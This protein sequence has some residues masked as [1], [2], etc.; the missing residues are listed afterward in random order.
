M[1]PG[2]KFDMWLLYC[3][4][5]QMAGGTA[6]LSPVTLACSSVVNQPFT[7]LWSKTGRHM[8]RE[9][10]FPLS[11]SHTI[12]TTQR[13]RNTAEEW[14]S[15]WKS[16]GKSAA[17]SC[18]EGEP[19]DLRHMKW[20]FLWMCHVIHKNPYLFYSMVAVSEDV[21]ETGCCKWGSGLSFIMF[22]LTDCHCLW[23]L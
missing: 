6:L 19:V 17:H 3:C 20:T 15:S 12:R 21:W 2:N 18:K 14:G 16:E 11:M 4:Y 7:S 8:H 9:V 5:Q 13:Q 22:C 23:L 10:H 1:N